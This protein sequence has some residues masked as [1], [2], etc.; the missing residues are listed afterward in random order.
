MVL[1]GASRRCQF[2]PERTE[3]SKT[4]M[5]VG[6]LLAAFAGGAVCTQVANAIPERASPY[7]NLGVFARA[8]AHIEMSYVEEVDQ[9]ALIYGAIRGMVETLDPHSSFMDP[10]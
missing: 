1:H 5:R 9:D 2:H 8:L 7:R 4:L 6:L 10:E 3:M